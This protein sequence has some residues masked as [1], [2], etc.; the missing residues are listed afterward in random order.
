MEAS[1]LY[2]DSYPIEIGVALAD[3]R[4]YCSL[5]KPSADWSHW[6][7]DAYM[8]HG[9]KR[10]TLIKKG[11]EAKTVARELNKTL[12]GMQVYSDA[13]VVDNPWLIKLFDSAKVMQQFRLS[14]IQMV[15]SEAQM[16]VWHMVKK[17]VMKDLNLTRHRASSDAQIIQETF[18]RT[19]QLTLNE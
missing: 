1:G 17:E 13:W 3:G 15:L 2:G 6:D 11:Q 16:A 7:N 18:I 10:S 12:D 8:V 19:A 5:I 9:I 14:D 4:H